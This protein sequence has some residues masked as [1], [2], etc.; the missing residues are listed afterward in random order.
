MAGNT[1]EYIALKLEDFKKY[2]SIMVF[3]NGVQEQLVQHI[4]KQF[5]LINII[6]NMQFHNHFLMSLVNVLLKGTEASSDVIFKISMIENYS[7]YLSNILVE[8]LRIVSVLHDVG[9]SF[10]VYMNGRVYFNSTVR[11]CHHIPSTLVAL[12]LLRRGGLDISKLLRRFLKLSGVDKEVV[13][14][15]FNTLI[16]GC[17]VSHHEPLESTNPKDPNLNLSDKYVINLSLITR[18]LENRGVLRR[19]N[20]CDWFSKSLF[21]I[22][23]MSKETVSEY[24]VGQKF[25]GYINGFHELD[26][27]DEND[28]KNIVDYKV[29]KFYEHAR[30]SE[31]TIKENAINLVG[32]SDLFYLFMILDYI[33]A[34]SNRLRKE[35][36][37]GKDNISNLEKYLYR[38]P[39]FRSVYEY[40]RSWGEKY[41]W[42]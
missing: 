17:V 9:K 32:F 14:K 35:S 1:Y 22:E 13:V 23:H 27:Y 19:D 16:S 33:S 31:K 41:D 42:W 12:E 4:R 18:F 8:Y 26:S 39:H 3:S 25:L 10:G 38:F 20:S 37:D 7:E 11:G 29:V 40:I 36:S 5:D 30:F 24:F 34:R 28:Y 21:E 2:G 6:E 15:N